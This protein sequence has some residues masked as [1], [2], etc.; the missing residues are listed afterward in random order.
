MNIKK[1]MNKFK[2]IYPYII[3]LTGIVITAAWMIVWSVI[4]IQYGKF[5]FVSFPLLI[6]LTYIFI[7]NLKTQ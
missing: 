7:K 4:N 3:F 1:I 2:K 6:M 5:G